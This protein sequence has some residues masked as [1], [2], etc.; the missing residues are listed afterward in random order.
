M[1]LEELRNIHHGK[2]LW[3]LG[4]GSSI[5]YLDPRFF[6]DKIVVA[7]NL[8]GELLKIPTFYL[9]SH[10]HWVIERQLDNEG[11]LAAVVQEPCSTRWSRPGPNGEK[12][13]QVVPEDDRI[14]LNYP[15]PAVPPGNNFDPFTTAHDDAIVFGSSSVHGSIHLAAMMGARYIVL[16]GTD[17]GTIDDQ[18]RLPGYYS[19]GDTP[20]KLYD[21][22]LIA[23]KR[24]VK[25]TYG[26]DT[27]SLNPFVNFN[28]EGHIFRG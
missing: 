25:A 15:D 21:R 13:W 14:V 27:Y 3:V 26:A 22:D 7:T 10:Y 8:I 6:D 11:I 18:H 17:C 23:M 20:W 19:G 24:W 16:V 9:F 12:E 1:K 5:G 4:S 28:L 2:T